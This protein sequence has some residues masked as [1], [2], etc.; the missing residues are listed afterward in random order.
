MAQLYKELAERELI[1][2]FR[3][4]HSWLG[5]VRSKPQWVSNDVIKIPRQG[6]DPQVLIN[7]KI[8]PIQSNDR[9]DDFIAVA[10]N[11]YDTTNTTVSDDEL[12]ALPYEKV[13]D[14][15]VQHREKL[16]QDTGEH[17][18]YSIAPAADSAK[19]PVLVTTGSND[20]NGRKRLTTIDLIN[21]KKELD[22]LAVPRRGRMLILCADHVADLLTEDLTFRNSYQNIKGGLISTSYMGFETWEDMTPV[23]YALDGGVLTKEAFGAVPTGFAASVVA[24]KGNL[25]KATGTVKRYMVKAENDPNNRRNTIGF[26]LY[27]IAVAIKDE[28]MGAI[29]S[30]AHVG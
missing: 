23:H 1:K 30:A 7:N 5:T 10:L 28:G 6:A 8:Y 12:E 3:H 25:A 18:L 29:V 22:V 16:E 11:K 19:T 17:A 9:E 27:F 24:F 13:S 26:R 4:E 21:Y 2:K 14:V 15:Q 20:G